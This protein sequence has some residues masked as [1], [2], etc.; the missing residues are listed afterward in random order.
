MFQFFPVFAWLAPATSLTMLVMLTAAGELRW[1]A[2]VFS[3]ALFL[4]ALSG[5]VF[6]SSALISA[7][8]L[9]LQ[10]LL[11]IGLIARWRLSV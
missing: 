2:G 8:A 7:A 11:A 1:R 6:S 4:L 10:T 9:A 5:Q 3:I